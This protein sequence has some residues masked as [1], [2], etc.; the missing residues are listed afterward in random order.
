MQNIRRRS[1]GDADSKVQ[2]SKLLIIY[3][4][5]HR[6]HCVFLA[7]WLELSSVSNTPAAAGFH[8]D[9]CQMYAYMPCGCIHESWP[10]EKSDS[11]GI[12]I[13]PTPQNVT[14][15]SRKR[16]V[17]MGHIY[18]FVLIHVSVM[19]TEYD[20]HITFIYCTVHSHVCFFSSKDFYA[21]LRSTDTV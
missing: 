5:L 9:A 8:M 19:L 21:F 17:L 14:C 3:S 7:T 16:S 11:R 1:W 20:L 15:E 6:H 13:H 2:D 10:K 12:S 4:R 18:T